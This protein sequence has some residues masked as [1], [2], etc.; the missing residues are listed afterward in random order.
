M[1]GTQ[2]NQFL[3]AVILICA[4]GAILN[5]SKV[6]SRGASAKYLAAAFISLGLGVFLIR[7]GANQILVGM[8][9]AVTFGLLAADFIHRLA[10]HPQERKR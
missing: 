7:Q 6:K 3:T 8:A 10:K 4:L 2:A 1:S 5:I 9:G